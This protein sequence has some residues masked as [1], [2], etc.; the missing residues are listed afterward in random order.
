MR[1]LFTCISLSR[2]GK[3]AATAI[4]LLEKGSTYPYLQK[5]Y[6]LLRVALPADFA[7][8]CKLFVQSPLNHDLSQYSDFGGDMCWTAQIML[9]NCSTKRIQLE[10][11]RDLT[12][13][14]E[15]VFSFM[16]VYFVDTLTGFF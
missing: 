7:A 15:Q 11:S 4:Q 5:P 8:R 2:F 12:T 10:K 1:H 14:S 3:A 9:S 6:Y 13:D 16:T